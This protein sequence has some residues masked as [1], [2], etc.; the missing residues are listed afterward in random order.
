MLYTSAC[1]SLACL[2]VLAH[3][4]KTRWPDEYLSAR[5]NLHRVPDTAQA[6]NPNDLRST[7]AQGNTWIRNTSGLALVVLSVVIP[8]E[9]YYDANVLL[10]PNHPDFPLLE[11]TYQGAFAFDKRFSSALHRTEVFGSDPA[12]RSLSSSA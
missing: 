11:W 8:G 12:S 10:N 3:L 5:T 4:D 7:Q 9:S 1:L 6:G 2:E